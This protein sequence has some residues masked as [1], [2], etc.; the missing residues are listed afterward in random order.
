[1]KTILTSLFALAF[2]LAASPS[3]AFDY[4][5]QR[6]IISPPL[7]PQSGHAP[8]FQRIHRGEVPTHWSMIHSY[9]AW[10]NINKTSQRRI[11]IR[12]HCHYY[13][14]HASR[15]KKANACYD[16]C[17]RIWERRDRLTNKIR[18]QQQEIEQ[19]KCLRKC[20]TKEPRQFCHTNKGVQV[21]P[22]RHLR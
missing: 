22:G 1:M 18:E 10:K 9:W 8:G 7:S 6:A 14:P 17:N 20:T 13:H 16:T 2:V 11:L 4:T 15:A 3:V 12:Y 5:R 19:A 21:S